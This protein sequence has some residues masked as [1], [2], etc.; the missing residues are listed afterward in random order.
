MIVPLLGTRQTSVIPDCIQQTGAAVQDKAVLPVVDHKRNQN[1]LARV[2]LLLAI[3]KGKIRRGSLLMDISS[4]NRRF[5][6]L[7]QTGRPNPASLAA[8]RAGGQSPNKRQGVKWWRGEH[9]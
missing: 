9:R 3:R 8:T 2:A 6:G 5:Q 1:L 4:L 7:F